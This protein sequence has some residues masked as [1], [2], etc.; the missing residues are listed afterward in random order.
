MDTIGA[1]RRV[2]AVQC[3]KKFVHA[4]DGVTTSVTRGVKLT[5]KVSELSS[6][7]RIVDI[8]AAHSRERGR[9]GVGCVRSECENGAAKR[10]TGY[11]LPDMRHILSHTTS[12]RVDRDRLEIKEFHDVCLA[13]GMTD[14]LDLGT[15]ALK[16]YQIIQR[17]LGS[18]LLELAADS[19][20]LRD[21]LRPPWDVCA[22][23]YGGQRDIL[24][25]GSEYGARKIFTIESTGGKSRS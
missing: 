25:G 16:G 22:K 21:I 20:L 11:D 5:E 4:E 24:R 19:K 1:R 18:K 15:E 13:S 10:Q 17:T 9:Y 3:C 7:V 2:A 12:E 23:R 8:R 14:S 6:E